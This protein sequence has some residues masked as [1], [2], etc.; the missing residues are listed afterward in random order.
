MIPARNIRALLR[1]DS[2][3]NLSGQPKPFRIAEALHVD[4]DVLKEAEWVE[5]SGMA[6]GKVTVMVASAKSISANFHKFYLPDGTELYLYGEN[7][8]M[9]LANPSNKP[10]RFSL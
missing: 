4:I 5:E 10:E 2:V 3:E 6:Y 1:Q 7:G 8:E 9:I